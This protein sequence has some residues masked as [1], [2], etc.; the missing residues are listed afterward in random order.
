MSQKNAAVKEFIHT[1]GWLGII[2][3]VMLCLIFWAG[4]LSLFRAE[5]QHWA[6]SVHYSIDDSKPDMPLATL[7]DNTVANYAF[8]NTKS[9]AVRLPHHPHQYINLYLDIKDDARKQ[10]GITSPFINVKVDPKTGA[11]IDDNGA[12]NLANFLYRLHYNLNLS[13]VGMYSIGIVTLFF[14]VALLSGIVIHAKKIVSHFFSYR[15][16][17]SRTHFLDLHNVIGVISLPYT[18]MYALTGLIF[19]LIIVYQITFAVALYNG[20]AN[21]L[22]QDAGYPRDQSQPLTQTSQNM[23]S[24]E[25]LLQKTRNEY[26]EVTRLRF[27]KYGDDSATVSMR[28][29]YADRF[30]KQ[31]EVVY[32]IK[33][34]EQ[35]HEGGVAH[36]NFQ[37]GIEF[38]QELH[39]GSFGSIDTRIV[40]FLLALGVVVVIITGNILWIEKRAYQMDKQ[41]STR[42]VANMTIGGCVG[43]VLAT[44]AAFLLERTLAP[45]LDNRAA[46]VIYGFLLTYATSL[47]SSCII[48]SKRTYL[49]L[50]LMLTGIIATLLL[51]ID[52]FLFYEHIVRQNLP[53]RMVTIGVDVGILFIAALC[54]LG[55]WYAKPKR[56]KPQCHRTI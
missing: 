48:A 50:T 45:T 26:G 25:P 36:N 44:A 35:L 43:L 33:T 13:K 1:H 46:L 53:Y 8:D 49:C 47:L 18:L 31:F 56:A 6:E 39:F 15:I 14:S 4:A 2:F 28:G 41:R 37:Q 16:H 9:L 10:L 51:L 17:K 20:D 12:F 27:V 38:L 29:M 30:T 19:N 21:Q 42:I 23:T 32:Q 54:F 52:G 3:S 55:A 22:L 5:I 7:I 34:G 11:I 40:Y 24:W